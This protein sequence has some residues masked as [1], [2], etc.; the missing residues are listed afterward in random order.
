M[1]HVTGSDAGGLYTPNG[2]HV[3]HFELKPSLGNNEFNAYS[4]K[5]C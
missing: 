4:A 2:V 3:H 5:I 1:S